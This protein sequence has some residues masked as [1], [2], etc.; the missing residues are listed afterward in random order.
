MCASCTNVC[1][2]KKVSL[3][4]FI[5]FVEEHGEGDDEEHE[6]DVTDPND[7]P[8]RLH[9]QGEVAGPRENH[10]L[11][12]TDVGHVCREHQ[13]GQLGQCEACHL[14][15]GANTRDEVGHDGGD[16]TCEMCLRTDSVRP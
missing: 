16:R 3:L 4:V 10:M 12:R 1:L 8:Q 6:D 15:S 14:Q 11:A 5:L 7:G 2:K 9:G 13:D